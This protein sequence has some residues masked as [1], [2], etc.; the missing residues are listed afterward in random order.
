MKMP[1]VSVVVPIY[2]AKKYLQKCIDSI[3]NQSYKNLEIILVDDGSTDG[4]GRIVDEY[5]KKD[6]RIKI[7]HQKNSGQS[8][9]RNVGIGI[10]RGEYIGFVDADDEIREDFYEKIMAKMAEGFELVATGV[11]YR[12]LDSGWQKNVYTNPV[13]VQKKNETLE[14]YAAY[15]MI[16]DGRMYGCINKLFRTE[17]ILRKKLHFDERINFAEDTKFVL[18]YL[19]EMRGKIGFVTEPLYI[20]NSA[21]ENSTMK[22]TSGDWKNWKRSFEELKSFAKKSASSKIRIRLLAIW[23]RWRVSWVR[24]KYGLR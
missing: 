1:L 6:R 10:S 8:C 12:R 22:K 7:V 15:L 19:A 4:S 24:T 21:T 17:I 2:N 3:L 23:M 13:R 18:E 20:Y 16:L 9:A 11:D 14:E 5:A